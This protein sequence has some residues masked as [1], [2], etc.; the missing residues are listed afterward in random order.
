MNKIKSKVN[1]AT[2]A[3]ITMLTFVISNAGIVLAKGKTDISK[4]ILFSGTENL[5]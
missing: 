1:K 2:T 4:S 3:I 5:F